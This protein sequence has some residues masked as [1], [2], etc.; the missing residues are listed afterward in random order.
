MA[1]VSPIQLLDKSMI[2]SFFQ[3]I[4]PSSYSFLNMYS[5]EIEKCDF[6]IESIT[7]NA[8]QNVPIF[9][10]TD[11]EE[12]KLL[13]ILKKQVWDTN[14]FQSNIGIIDQYYKRTGLSNSQLFD[15]TNTFLQ[16]LD[17][18]NFFDYSFIS[19]SINSWDSGIS[20]A[21][22]KWMFNYILTWIDA[23]IDKRL[24]VE[25][26]SHIG[27]IEDIN[28]SHL[29]LFAKMSKTDYFKGGRFYLD[30]SFDTIK[31]DSLYSNL[32]SN[33]Y[34]KN[35][36]IEY[37][38][39]NI[40]SGL[41]IVK[42]EDEICGLKISPLRYLLLDPKNRKSGL[43]YDFFSLVISS[44]LKK[45]DIVTSGL[46]VHNLPSLNLHSKLNFRFTYT[47]NVYHWRR[48]H[49]NGGDESPE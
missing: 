16:Y 26:K 43:G 29:E 27:R 3:D 34:K 33:S 5:K 18:S 35:N 12:I 14:H 15:L 13:F 46:E 17:A 31:V 49:R 9:C 37:Y 30:Y 25:K 7:Q 4:T 23:V 8:N 10:I 11:E 44:L 41:F 42:P 32:V 22:Q 48:L 39:D 38:V 6:F 1:S 45:T 24:F 19:I 28:E 36:M 40:P 2:E 20:K 21:F 47:H